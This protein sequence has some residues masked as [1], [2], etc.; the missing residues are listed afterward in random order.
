MAV[1]E[2]GVVLGDRMTDA[3]ADGARKKTGGKLVEWP[4]TGVKL[5]SYIFP[6]I[7]ACYI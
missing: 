4:L 7:T 2:A 6:L 1:A 5:G 3:L